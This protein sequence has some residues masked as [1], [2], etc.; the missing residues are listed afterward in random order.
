MY[1]RF[2]QLFL[3]QDELLNARGEQQAVRLAFAQV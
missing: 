1:R 3:W 2:V